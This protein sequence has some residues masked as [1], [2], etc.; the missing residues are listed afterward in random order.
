MHN[1]KIY[2]YKRCIELY[3]RVIYGCEIPSG[4]I[5]GK[6]CKFAHNALGVVLH[7]ETV[8]GDNCKIGQYV[9]IGGRSGFEVV[10]KIGNNVEIGAGALILGPIVIGDNVKIGAGAIVVKDIP[11][12]SIVR[13]KASDIYMS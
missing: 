1:S 8:I 3:L 10:P 7:P 9:T 13:S 4:V 12:N 6:N 11:A 2:A 5:I